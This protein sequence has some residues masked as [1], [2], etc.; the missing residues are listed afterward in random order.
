MLC[1]R[2]FLADM[3]SAFVSALTNGSSGPGCEAA[4]SSS[5]NA[6]RSLAS[7]ISRKTW[8]EC[9]KKKLGTISTNSLTFPFDS[10]P[11]IVCFFNAYRPSVL[12]GHPTGHSERCIFRMKIANADV[13]SKVCHTRLICLR[14]SSSHI[15]PKCCHVVEASIRSRICA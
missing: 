2:R 1:R 4:S 14:L 15:F 3:S 13:P 11:M 10:V 8:K 9:K 6:R 12:S 5:S 7:S